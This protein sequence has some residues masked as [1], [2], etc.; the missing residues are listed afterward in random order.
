MTGKLEDAFVLVRAE[1]KFQVRELPAVVP[2]GLQPAAVVEGGELDPQN[3]DLCVGDNGYYLKAYRAGAGK[4][5]LNL[6]VPVG[7]RRTA[8][9][10]S[11]ERGFNL[12]LP[13]AV[14]TSLTLDL[15]Q[16]IKEIRCK[17]QRTEGRGPTEDAG[18]VM[19]PKPAGHWEMPSLGA[20]KNLEVVWKEPVAGAG[21]KPLQ[22]A[23]GD[24]VVRLATKARWTCRRS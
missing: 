5:T 17:T 19:K 18:L 16:N 20:V 13:G 15:P 21:T 6:K 8:R 3:F 9:G 14:I 1:V 4:L 7:P 10:G 23:V 12:A 24:I 2:L 22:S 11:D